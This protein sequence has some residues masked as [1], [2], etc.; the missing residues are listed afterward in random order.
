MMADS[1]PVVV[2]IVLPLPLILVPRRIG[3]YRKALSM[4]DDYC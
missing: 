2:I 4:L 3:L 1:I